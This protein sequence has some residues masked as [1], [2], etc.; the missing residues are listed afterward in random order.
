M[1]PEKTPNSQSNPEKEIQSWRHHN[2]GLQ[3]VL[4]SCNHQDSMVLAQKQTHRLLEENR[5][6]RNG[7]I[8]VWTTH[9]QQSRKEYPMEQRQS[10]QQMVLG[11]LDSDMQ[12]NEAG[13]FSY[14][15]HKN[16]LKMD[17]RPKCETGNHQNPTGENRQQPL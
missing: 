11:K 12:Q 15:I 6:P 9:L 7:P 1:E 2:S 16:K 5:E 14:I 3:S 8:N 17:E 13:P 10:L 4:Q